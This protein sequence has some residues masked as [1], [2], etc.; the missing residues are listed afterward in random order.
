M[1]EDQ[2]KADGNPRMRSPSPVKIE[3]K[4]RRKPRSK[5]WD[6][7]PWD[8]G[9]SQ[10]MGGLE[11]QLKSR[12]RSPSPKSQFPWSKGSRSPKRSRAKSPSRRRS[13]SRSR[14]R[15]RDSSRD[16]H[17][18]E[19]R[20]YSNTDTSNSSSQNRSRR[21]FTESVP[22]KWDFKTATSHWD[23]GDEDSPTDPSK[24]RTK[25]KFQEGPA[26]FKTAGVRKFA[27][28]PKLIEKTKKEAEK[29][30]TLFK[31]KPKDVFAVPISPAGGMKIGNLPINDGIIPAGAMKIAKAN[32]QQRPISSLPISTKIDQAF[33]LPSPSSKPKQSILKMGALSNLSMYADDS[34]EDD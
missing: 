18:S 19:E 8:E 21:K 14:E 29:K 5:N 6:K 27:E 3:D 17:S 1:M 10:K 23:E 32:Q 16:R 9:P 33:K 11:L 7:K 31:E 25:R 28:D 26:T 15:R 24:P 2:Q 12:S 34:D 20:D 22:S 13:R 4:P 30:A